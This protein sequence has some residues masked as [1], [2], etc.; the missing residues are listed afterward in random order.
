ME[1]PDSQLVT[2]SQSTQ[3]VARI[4][5]RAKRATG[6]LVLTAGMFTMTGWSSSISSILFVLTYL[7]AGYG[8]ALGIS[9]W[10]DYRRVDWGLV[11]WDDSNL[12]K[13]TSRPYGTP[14][15]SAYMSCA[16]TRNTVVGLVIAS[17]G[18]LLAILATSLHRGWFLELWQRIT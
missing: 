11:D 5:G 2:G 9:G 17:V 4:H 7:L 8:L 1:T 13:E 3:L 15:R 18:G 12:I 10:V 14:P 16:S 6:I